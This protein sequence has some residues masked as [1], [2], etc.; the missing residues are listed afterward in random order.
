MSPDNLESLVKQKTCFKNTDNSSCI[1]LI[2]TNSPRSFQDS[3]LFEAGLSDFHK[4][5]IT[6]LKQYF[7]KPKPK[8]VKYR[9]YRNFRNDEF[10]AELGNEIL[11]HNI[12]NSNRIPTFL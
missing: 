11:I 5:T 9:D 6:V 7:P 2:L 1:E 10:R 4:L 3:S 12:N 8:I